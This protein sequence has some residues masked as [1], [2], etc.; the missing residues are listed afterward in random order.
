MKGKVKFVDR[1]KSAFYATLRE[2]VDRYFSEQ[3]ISRNANGAMVF[4]TIVLMSMYLGPLVVMSIFHPPL[5]VN[6]MLW[7]VMGF[8]LA[9]I[10]MSVMHDAN[11]GA[12]SANETV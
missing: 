12:Y 8:G 3:N 5:L 7:S 9:G 4:K 11:H 2:N 1:D 6:L 10:G